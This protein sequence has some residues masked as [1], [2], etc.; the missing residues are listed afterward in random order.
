MRAVCLAIVMVALATGCT[1]KNPNL[2][3]IDAADCEAQ[4][5]PDNAQCADGLV[6]RGNQCI[7]ESCSSAADCDLAAPYCVVEQ[8]RCAE[9]CTVDAQC[10]GFSQDPSATFCVGGACVGCRDGMNDCAAEAPVCDDGACRKCVENSDCTSGACA[11][12]GSCVAEAD[13]AFVSPTATATSGCTRAAPCTLAGA[14]AV[15][16]ARAVVELL[17]GAYSLPGKTSVTGVRRIIGAPDSRPRITH[18]TAGDIFAV[19]NL[20]DVSFEHLEIFGA[21]ANDPDVGNAI[22]CPR[23]PDMSVART[24]RLDDVIAHDNSAAAVEG[25]GCTFFVARST[26]ATSASGLVVVNGNASVDRCNVTGNAGKGLDLDTG[27]YAVT[28]NFI[29]RNGTGVSAFVVGPGSTFNFNTIVDN[30]MLSFIGSPNG[31]E[32]VSFA[33][34]VVARTAA[35]NQILCDANTTCVM[36]GTIVST[37]VV[38]F[39]F[40][41]PDV[42]PFDYHLTAGSKAIDAA[43]PSVT[44]MFDAD[45][46]ARPQGAA[47]DVG[48]DEAKQ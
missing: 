27:G 19:P 9:A 14:L 24:V 4:G 6:C 25:N 39:H 20:A 38:D 40:K 48:A 34:N 44:T 31:P 1:K 43:D 47:M 26:L 22:S 3:C 41:S 36:T 11:S 23:L 46:D 42:A 33:N 35:A 32:T 16:P 45:G 18:S 5:L 21:T 15:T 8:S 10:P 12:D 30:T 13:I 17:G 7:A 28:N 2:C 37:D 29:T